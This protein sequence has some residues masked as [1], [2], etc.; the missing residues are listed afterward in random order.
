MRHIGLVLFLSVNLGGGFGNASAEVISTTEDGVNV[1]I[2]V[3]VEVSADSVVAHLTAP[4]EA[5]L[6]LP[7]LS[8]G[9]GVYEIQTDLPAVDYQVVFEALGPEGELSTPVSLSELGAALPS[10]P[11]ATVPGDD[12][13]LGSDV[14][15]WG[16]LALALAAAS[17]S[18]LAF[19]VLGGSDKDDEHDGDGEV[20]AGEAG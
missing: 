3:E 11:G 8:T 15:R 19:W 2:Q 9:S 12:E 20:A 7:M 17:L 1:R 4:G 5:E 10:Q 18:A 13:G 14:T 6:T 16:W